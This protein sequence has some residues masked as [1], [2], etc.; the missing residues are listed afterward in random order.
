M[1]S[2]MVCCVIPAYRARRT[3]C[4]VVQKALNYVD[5][6]IVVDDACPEGTG[7]AVRREF[8]GNPSVRV[9]K[10]E[11]NGGVGAATKTGIGIAL[12]LEADIIVKIDA[13]DQMDSSYIPAIVDLFQSDP[14]LALIKGNRFADQAVL[15]QMPALRL[16]GNAMLSILV[17]FASGYWNVLDP[18]NGYLAFNAHLLRAIDWNSFANGYFFETSVLCELG[19]KH[20]NIAE[21]EMVT[22]YGDAGS[23]LS[24]AHTVL[25]FPRRLAARLIRRILLQYFIFDVNLG[26]LYL[27]LGL[28]LA[29]GGAGFAGFQWVESA[30]TNVPRTTG[31]VMLAVLPFLMGFQLVLNALLHDVQFAPRVRRE[32]L[33]QQARRKTL[34]EAARQI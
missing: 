10:R 12:E 19:L 13:D 3:I 5:R 1:E 18:T 31:T 34:H 23:S 27:L 25:D 32:L 21:V 20:A 7:E 16:F 2:P 8:R 29:A 33:P 22:I 6:V 28:M 14:T 30:V 24:I 15:H 26:S 9:V 11:K 17:K 4:G